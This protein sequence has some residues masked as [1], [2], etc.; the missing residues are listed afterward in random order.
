MTICPICQA[1]TIH[2]IRPRVITYKKREKIINQPAVYCDACGDFFLSPEDSKATERE[3]A[4]FRRTVEHLLTSEEIKSIRK[5]FKITQK[6]ASELFG[7]GVNAFSKYE[8]GEAIQSRS[9]DILLRL[10]EQEK[11][12][13]R[14]IKAMI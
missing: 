11:V 5:R 9:T 4:D 8:R 14:E 3:M 7:G 12:G 1:A 6:E 13:V 10:I 2:E